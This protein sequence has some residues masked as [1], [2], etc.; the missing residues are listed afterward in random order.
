VTFPGER[1][2]ER[3]KKGIGGIAPGMES[4]IH[5]QEK[6]ENPVGPDYSGR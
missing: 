4:L 6:A 1:I 3:V 2:V 5:H